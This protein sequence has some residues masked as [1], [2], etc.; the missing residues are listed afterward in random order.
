MNSNANEPEPGSQHAIRNPE[1]TFEPRDLS[2]RAVL[3]FL[4]ALAI[5]GVIVA[6][7][8]WGVYKYLAKEEYAQPRTTNPLSTSNRELRQ[9]GGDPAVTFPA[10]RLQPDPT[11]DMNKFR[12]REE[13]LLNTYGWIDQSAGKVHIP[14]ERAIDLVAQTG[15]PTVPEAKL[16]PAPQPGAAGAAGGINVKQGAGGLPP[17]EQP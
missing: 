16:P 6:Y 17:P 10:P 13:E 11:A 1:V 7:G 9:V 14:I 3:G 5:A 12:A 2:V 4:I 15:L 8:L